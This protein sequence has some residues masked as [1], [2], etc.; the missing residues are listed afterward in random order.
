MGSI[1][2]TQAKG[3]KAGIWSPAEDRAAKFSS[4]N[5]FDGRHEILPSGLASPLPI[6][7]V[8]PRLDLG[9]QIKLKYLYERY[10]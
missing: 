8:A 4:G 6:K 5:S 9:F 10:P 2:F 3:G 1:A 7:F